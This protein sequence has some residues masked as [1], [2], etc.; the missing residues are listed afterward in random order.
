MAGDS[1]EA[2]IEG[3]KGAGMRQLFYNVQGKTDLPFRP[4]YI[5]NGWEE[6]QGMEI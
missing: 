1:W 5:I 3:A 6:I 2:D 4:T